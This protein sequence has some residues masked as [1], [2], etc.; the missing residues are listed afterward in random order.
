MVIH[1]N[2]RLKTTE[3]ARRIVLGVKG[4]CRGS[5]RGEDSLFDQAQRNDVV[6][7]AD[8]SR[9]ITPL[10]LAEEGGLAHQRLC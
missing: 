8:E 9:E 10:E 4:Q 7:K 5:V 6:Y 3:C 1:I 2:Y